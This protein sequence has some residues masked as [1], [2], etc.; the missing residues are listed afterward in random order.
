MNVR[1][2][3]IILA[4]SVAL[5]VA[6]CSQPE[7]AAP[8]DTQ[9]EEAA[10]PVQIEQVKKGVVSSEAGISA[11]LAPSEEIQISPK[12]S[13]KIT[14]LPVKLGQ[15]VKKGE[16]LFK[17]DET[18]LANTVAQQ[19]A[20]YKV[21]L[22]NLKQSGSSTDQSLVQAQ[23]SLKQAEQALTDA[24]LNQQRMKQLFDQ[25][26]ISSQQFEQANTSLMN[27]QT[28]YENA[29][30]TLETTKQKT[31]LQV[32]EASVNQAAV[33]L[34]NAREQLANAVVTAPISGFVSSVNGAVGQIASQGTPVVVIV[35][36]NPLLVKAN[37]SEQDITK[38]KVGTAV[39]V[40]IPILGKEVEAKVSAVSPVMNSQLK[41][42][43]IEISIPNPS[44]EL[45]ADMVVNVTFA[46]QVSGKEEEL[47][48]PR[49]AVFEREGK[50]FVFRI[51]DEVAKQ[52][53]VTTGE[54]TSDQ[55]VIK[56]GLAEGD[57]VV[58]KGQTLLQDGKKVSIIQ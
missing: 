32:S 14:S 27:A 16:V 2:Q 24:Q 43:P 21:A 58:V 13:G 39:K 12:V 5:L 52:V 31:T 49:K 3:P 6:G 17:L 11:K 7:A 40:N 35:N 48:V 1:K 19:E 54:E 56:S 30:Q 41:A 57:K 44:N 55:I 45:K 33:A 28:A 51:E 10:T 9:A 42:Y 23:N 50:K 36:T 34:Q 15:P 22:A 29:K 46:G 26:A 37:L 53:E 18:D 38:V 8:S 4:L 25:G 20:A 47:I